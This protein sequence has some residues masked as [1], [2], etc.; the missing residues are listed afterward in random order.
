MTTTDQH[1][2]FAA[3]EIPSHGSTVT[4]VKV[5]VSDWMTWR[6]AIDQWTAMDDQRSTAH[7][8]GGLVMHG[9]HVI[10]FYEVRSAADPGYNGLDTL[11]LVRGF[12]VLTQPYA[13]DTYAAKKVLR[14]LG[15]HAKEG[16]WVYEGKNMDGSDCVVNQG[17]VRTASMV[18]HRVVRLPGETGYRAVATTSLLVRKEA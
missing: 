2:V 6:E 18:G 14:P 7:A 1:A 15:F 17:W 11:N 5:R 3:L 10:R 4:L 16:G 12:K 8:T 9:D 13:S